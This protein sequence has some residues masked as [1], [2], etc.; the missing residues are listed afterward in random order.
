MSGFIDAEGCFYIRTSEKSEKHPQRLECKFELI[1]A[2]RCLNG[3]DTRQ[4]LDEIGELLLSSV[5]ECKQSA[6]CPQY[7]VRTTSLEGNLR[8]VEYLITFPLFTSKYL[9][10]C[11]WLVLIKRFE[12]KTHKSQDS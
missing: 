9:N 4:T 7:R 12:A 1:Q 10:F 5:K 11:D 3:Y 6:K 2:Q 8:L